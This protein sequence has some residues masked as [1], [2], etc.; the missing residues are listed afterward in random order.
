MIKTLFKNLWKATIRYL[1]FDSTLSSKNS[2]YVK[3]TDKDIV[4]LTE[5]ITAAARNIEKIKKEKI[6]SNEAATPDFR[7]KRDR[8]NVRKIRIFRAFPESK[9]MTMREIAAVR[10]LKK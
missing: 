3:D 4:E 5:R 8:H 1:G 10:I 9:V 2:P 7:I 6:R